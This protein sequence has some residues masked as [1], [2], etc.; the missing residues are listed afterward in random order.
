MVAESEFHKLMIEKWNSCLQRVGHGGKST[1][2]RR[3]KV[4]IGVNV[5]I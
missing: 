2:T 3:S 1:L 4:E 5:E